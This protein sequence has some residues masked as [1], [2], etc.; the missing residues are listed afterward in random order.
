MFTW[1]FVP[2]WKTLVFIQHKIAFFTGGN[3]YKPSDEYYST[4]SDSASSSDSGFGA[5]DSVVSGG[6]SGQVQGGY[7]SVI[8]RED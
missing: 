7:V 8:A 4:S 5:V 1:A 3:W 6:Q 2:L